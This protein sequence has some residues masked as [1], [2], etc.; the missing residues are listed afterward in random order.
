MSQCALE[1]KETRCV[2]HHM[3]ER[4][5]EVLMAQPLNPFG[6]LTLAE[7]PAPDRQPMFQNDEHRADIGNK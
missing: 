7:R 3:S 2:T 6:E 5:R 1:Q 4:V